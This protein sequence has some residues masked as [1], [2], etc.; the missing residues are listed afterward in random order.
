MPITGLQR[1]AKESVVGA[2]DL[3]LDQAPEI[4][5]CLMMPANDHFWVAFPGKPMID[6]DHQV[7]RDEHQKFRYSSILRWGHTPSADR[8]DG[9]TIAAIINKHGEAAL[10]G[11]QS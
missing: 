11:G 5:G 1:I 8:F 10:D 6:P 4:A 3:V 7:Q 9:A 2:V